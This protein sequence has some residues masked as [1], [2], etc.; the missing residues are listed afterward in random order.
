MGQ[1]S[2]GTTN[3][4]MMRISLE[5]DLQRSVTDVTKKERDDSL[6]A[7]QITNVFSFCRP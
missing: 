1:K 6:V 2:G 4:Q 3:C 7:L 5:T